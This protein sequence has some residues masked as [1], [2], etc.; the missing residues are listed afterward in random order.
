MVEVDFH[1]LCLALILSKRLSDDQALDQSKVEA[2]AAAV[3]TEWA[4]RWANPS[5]VTPPTPAAVPSSGG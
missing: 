5:R 1:L 3:L 4:K 2:E